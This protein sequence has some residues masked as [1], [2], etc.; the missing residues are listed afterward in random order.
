MTIR[1]IEFD[2]V[3][4]MLAYE[5][6]KNG[7]ARQKIEPVQI[8][9]AQEKKAE[10]AGDNKRQHR[11]Y[12][13]KG[14]LPRLVAGINE[15]KTLIQLSKETDIPYTTLIGA[16][17]R[18][19]SVAPAQEKNPKVRQKSHL[20]EQRF[21]PFSDEEVT[22]VRQAFEK[23]GKLSM[24]QLQR[25]A[26]KMRIQF[27]RLK[28]IYY[29]N[30]KGWGIPKPKVGSHV[31]INPQDI[32]DVAEFQRTAKRNEKGKIA[33]RERVKFTRD[34]GMTTSR[35]D[36]I[37]D[38]VK[39]SGLAGEDKIKTQRHKF[40]W[41]RIKAMQSGDP[42]ASVNDLFY[43]ATEEWNT[44]KGLGK[45]HPEESGQKQD[46]IV[47]VPSKP[48]ITDEDLVF[49][50]IYPLAN[51]AVRVFEQMMIDLIAKKH[52]K[53]DYYLASSNLQCIEGKEWDYLTWMEFCRQVLANSKKIAKALIGCDSAKIRLEKE[54]KSVSIRYG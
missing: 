13:W 16:W 31:R 25:L 42:R 27:N 35:F 17:H 24:K 7:A 19:K 40:L 34:K 47:Y 28:T 44:H 36:V 4:E 30:F 1:I 50:A 52:G 8:A 6:K 9:P 48:K 3:E 15:G 49:P 41:Q 54:G 43:R 12:D 53:I 39:A 45:I 18:S 5:R 51:G 29:R 22:E 10:T 32:D 14:I 33:F 37:S 46:K 2:D 38:M 21:K 26:N 11:N 20:R 23:H